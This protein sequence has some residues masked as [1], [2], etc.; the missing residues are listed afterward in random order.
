MTRMEL[1]NLLMD[2]F[3]REKSGVFPRELAPDL[4]VS[5]G[6]WNTHAG[7][8]LC[9]LLFRRLSQCPSAANLLQA[10]RDYY[11]AHTYER[12]DQPRGKFFHTNWTGS[13]GNHLGY[14]LQ[15]VKG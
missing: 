8:Y 11:G 15:R 6:E 9:L 7:L 13:G 2:P 1:T 5:P 3:F 14:Y 4:R 12:V 10:Q